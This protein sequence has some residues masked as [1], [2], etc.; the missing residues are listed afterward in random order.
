MTEQSPLGV[1]KCVSYRPNLYSDAPVATFSHP[2]VARRTHERAV[3]CETA[4]RVRRDQATC[5]RA[6]YVQALTAIENNSSLDSGTSLAPGH[7]SAHCETA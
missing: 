5:S 7:A 6:F 3:I 4:L 1:G 2:V